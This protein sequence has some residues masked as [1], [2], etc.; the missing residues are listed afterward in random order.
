MKAL[1]IILI[2][3]LTIYPIVELTRV[4]IIWHTEI[5]SPFVLKFYFEIAFMW[6]FYLAG[7]SLISRV[8]LKTGKPSRL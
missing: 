8:I 6:A 4:I 7:L 2:C 3:L 5:S 1:L